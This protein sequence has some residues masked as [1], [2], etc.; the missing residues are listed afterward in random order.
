ME[1]RLAE[2]GKEQQI[3][4]FSEHLDDP[5]AQLMPTTK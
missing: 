1:L 5:E 2:M 4:H 3:E